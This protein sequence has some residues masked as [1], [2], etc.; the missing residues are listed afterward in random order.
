MTPARILRARGSVSRRGASRRANSSP[1]ARCR[2]C[3]GRWRAAADARR[4]RPPAIGSA[5]PITVEPGLV[6]PLNLPSWRDFPLR[7]LVRDASGGLPVT[8]RMDGEAITLAEHWIGAAQG[9]DNVMGMVVSTGIGGGLILGG[10]AVAGPTGN[11]GHIG[12]VE[13][14]GFDDPC[15]VRRR[16]AVSK[17]SR[18][19]PT[20][21]R[22]RAAR[23]STGTTG[24]DLA[25]RLCR[26]RPDRHRGRPA[27]RPRDR[28]GDRLG[29][30]AG[31][32]RP[33]RDR[34]RVLA[35]LARPA[36]LRA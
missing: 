22:G 29:D 32:P 11:A 10:I 27:L 31:R 1:S 14:G 12:H 26:R 9:V 21:S 4:S 8:L 18:P 36:R 33:R 34:R 5:G 23:D 13:V 7:D 3:S 20:R 30:G 16:S 15:D 24:E 6:S 25:A 28:P 17:P 35:R 2:S 19:G